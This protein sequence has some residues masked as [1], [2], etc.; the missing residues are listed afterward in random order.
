MKSAEQEGESKYHIIITIYTTGPLTLREVITLALS[1]QCLPYLL[2][3]ETYSDVNLTLQRML[4][5][6]DTETEL[7]FIYEG[8]A[9]DVLI[10]SR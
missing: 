2:S 8:I 1:S 10:R 4:L 9:C 5:I 6:P 3:Y 7:L